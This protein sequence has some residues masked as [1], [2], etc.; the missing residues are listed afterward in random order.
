MANNQDTQTG[1]FSGG[2]NTTG[3]NQV[4]QHSEATATAAAEQ[5]E[6]AETA[7]AAG[8]VPAEQSAN[9]A[10]Q[11]RDRSGMGHCRRR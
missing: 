1:E 9:E 3:E 4:D 10:E 2:E 7:S 5:Q 8:T 11:P 6:S